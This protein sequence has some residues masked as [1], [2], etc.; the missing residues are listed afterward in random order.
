MGIRLANSEPFS[1]QSGKT[2]FKENILKIQTSFL[3]YSITRYWIPLKKIFLEKQKIK[4]LKEKNKTYSKIVKEIK[5][6]IYSKVNK[7]DVIKV[8]IQWLKNNISN[9]L[10]KKDIEHPL[11]IPDSTRIQ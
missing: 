4:L 7:G 11:Q 8:H 6:K 1:R 3:D 9:P 2:L 10:I 5:K